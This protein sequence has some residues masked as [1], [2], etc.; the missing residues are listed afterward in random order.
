MMFWFDLLLLVLATLRFTRLVTNDTITQPLRDYFQG[1]DFMDEL[2]HCPF[3]IGWYLGAVIT[4][5]LWLAGGPGDA[6]DW[7]RY[8]A[9]VFALNYVVAH[10]SSRLDG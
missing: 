4:A 1:S 5:A 3:C 10:V 2:L 8:G 7:W 9:G 6:A